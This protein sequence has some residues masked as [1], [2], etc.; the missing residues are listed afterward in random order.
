M[1]IPT[2]TD[3]FRITLDL[4]S[5]GKAYS[6]KEIFQ[7]AKEEL[8]ITADEEEVK[9]ASGT[10]AYIG[11]VDWAIVY[12]F[13]GLLLDRVS[14]GVYKINDRGLEI[15]NTDMRGAEF[16][17]WLNREIAEKN[18]WNQGANSKKEAQQKSEDE[19]EIKS[20]REQI[21][22]L[23]EELNEVLASE[24][25]QLIL[26]REPAF[27]E[28]LVV[29]LLEKMGYGNGEITQYSSDG[30]IDGIIT[31]D[32]LGFDPIYTQAKRYALTSKV[33]RSEVQA[34]AGA[35]GSVSRGVFITTSSFSS[36]AIE[37]ARGYPHATLVLIDGEKLARL[38]IRYDLG[39]TVERAFEIKRVDS[40]YFDDVS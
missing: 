33:G 35:L 12:L 16:S 39:V 2:Q 17:H 25:V 9:L 34:F 5:D 24:L 19:S 29:D 13:R 15:V 14:R 21:E 22:D 10:P 4:L 31:T 23:S 32:A 11:R 3:A 36:G 37:W 20:P 27:L 38:M 18:P 28:K 26:D 1:P 6:R 7:K 8:G 30:G 40:D